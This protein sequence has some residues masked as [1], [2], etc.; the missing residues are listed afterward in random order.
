[1]NR[2]FRFPVILLAI[3]ALL[4]PAWAQGDLHARISFDA[5]GTMVRGTDDA[6]WSFATVNTLILPGDTLW[7]DQ[8]ATAEM[9][10]AG[11]TFVRMADGS[12]AVIFALSPVELRAST[13]SF[14]VHRISRSTGDVII[15]TPAGSVLVDRDTAARID[16]ASDGSTIVSVHWGSA[17]V[18]SG[19]GGGQTVYDRERVYVDPGYLPSESVSFDPA[20]EDDFDAWN[21]ERSQILV[22]G[23]SRI[24]TTVPV[25]N[26]TIGIADLSSY[27][28]WITHENRP[29]WRPTVE[30]NYV[31][32]RQGHWSYVPSVGSVWV[33]NDPFSY[34]TSHYGRWNYIHR[35][36]W[37]WQYDRQWSPAWVASVRY[38]DNMLWTPVGF[39]NR[40]V[41]VTN[42]ATFN[43]AGVLFSLVASSFVPQ[44]Q[45][46][47]GPSYIAPVRPVVVQNINITNIN[48]WNIG[49]D[50]RS[51]HVNVPYKDNQIREYQHRPDRVIRGLE[52]SKRNDATAHQIATNLEQKTRQEPKA[53]ATAQ[54]EIPKQA[55]VA[56]PDGR[57]AKTREVRLEREQRQASRTPAEEKVAKRSSR[58]DETLRPVPDDGVV[59]G[60]EQRAKRRDDLTDPVAKDKP[61]RSV[62]K[63]QRPD[64][65]TEDADRV[66]RS[67]QTE[68]PQV[69]QPQVEQPPTAVKEQKQKTKPDA[70][71]RETERAKQDTTPAER[72]ARIKADTDQKAKVKAD[73]KQKA[74]SKSDADRQAKARAEA[75]RRTQ[76]R[77]EAERQVRPKAEVDSQARTKA[78]A[79]Q[80]AARSRS[81]SDL[82]ARA[83][84]ERS[85]KKSTPEVDRA[86]SRNRAEAQS[87]QRVE[88][89]TARPEEAQVESGQPPAEPEPAPEARAR[90]SG[91]KRNVKQRDRT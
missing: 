29:Y 85:I 77:T 17:R 24:P 13:G 26:D 69:E 64:A 86:Q 21:R 51:H 49:T 3:A 59:I 84:R 55:T 53:K 11:G 58:T 88:S 39:D 40:P 27:G 19:G 63:Q 33:G 31:P 45:L 36:G 6:D 8:G 35:Y 5:G 80:R 82:R 52:R 38:G 44:N 7:A 70:T 81:E 54:G 1:M 89:P 9:E 68:Q 43:I 18:Q 2:I 42:T 91:E 4:A 79:Q 62:D 46:Y 66:R 28:D 12:R 76:S 23:V 90:Q 37:V 75:D 20:Y 14:Y 61:K 67:R 15:Q 16:I 74:R 60:D 32:Y 47:Y 48:I 10:L 83:N 57:R 25:S 72:Q 78:Q 65:R 87:P 34:V 50:R 30:S 71:A 41:L 73:N 56:D 22:T